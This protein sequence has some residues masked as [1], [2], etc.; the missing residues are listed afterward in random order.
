MNDDIIAAA[1]NGNTETV[2]SLL[3]RGADINAKDSNGQTALMR[4]AYEGHLDIVQLLLEYDA[5]INIT[6]EDG[7]TALQYAQE[8]EHFEISNLLK[9]AAFNRRTQIQENQPTRVQTPVSTNPNPQRLPYETPT[10][11]PPPTVIPTYPS[12]VASPP[13]QTASPPVAQRDWRNAVIIGSLIGGAILIGLLLTRSPQFAVLPSNNSSNTT[14]SNQ[15]NQ[16]VTP[17]SQ[18]EALALIE[19]WQTAK[20]QIFAPPFNRQILAEFNTGEIYESN[21]GSIIWLK[22]N[23]AAYTYRV[24]KI[25]SVEQFVADGDQASIE[26]VIT[27]DRTLKING[28]IDRQNTA[29]DTRLVRYNLRSDNGKW[30]I[31]SYNTIEK[32][33]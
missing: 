27:E 15:S 5:D 8:F 31:E 19:R 7:W 1:A 32:I 24:Q 30:K 12:G 16:S 13:P 22:D 18:Q 17:I 9:D 29:L 2:Q 23:N 6:D 3:N 26:V 14:S 28:K 20:K 33:Q 4:A 11:S 10:T 21:L 25:D